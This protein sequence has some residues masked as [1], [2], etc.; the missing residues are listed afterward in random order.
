[1]KKGTLPLVAVL[2]AV[3]ILG[4]TVFISA[5]PTTSEP[6]EIYSRQDAL[7]ASVA[8]GLFDGAGGVDWVNTLD[9]VLPPE[10][11]ERLMR[12]DPSELTVANRL[13]RDFLIKLSEDGHT[14]DPNWRFSDID[15]SVYESFVDEFM[16]KE[17][18]SMFSRE[19]WYTSD[20]LNIK[21]D[22]S[23]ADIRE[24]GNTVGEIIIRNS[25]EAEHELVLFKK[26]METGE[27][28]YEQR[29]G[30]ISSGCLKIAEEASAINVPE[31]AVD[32]HLDF[33][34]MMKLTGANVGR[35]ATAGEDPIGAVIS[36][37]AHIEEI[38]SSKFADL[39]LRIATYF[40]QKGVTY[41]GYQYG[42][43]YFVTG[44]IDLEQKAERVI[45]VLKKQP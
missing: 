8:R 19:E 16:E 38:S 10:E 2:F 30:N 21:Q 22:S 42:C 40:K 20:D 39:P 35:M 27:R 13:V 32:I 18:V 31:D 36:L 45:N 9:K 7:T 1:M 4:G 11:R 17:R 43:A 14:G 3:I 37:N 12:A 23:I 6:Y 28:S 24:Y 44:C 26:L 34:N 15:M 41:D 29:L 25:E 5:A 33:I